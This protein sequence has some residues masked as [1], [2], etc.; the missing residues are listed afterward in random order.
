MGLKSEVDGTGMN[1]TRNLTNSIRNV[2]K[3]VCKITVKR[4]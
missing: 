2:L 3:K 4:S 1:F